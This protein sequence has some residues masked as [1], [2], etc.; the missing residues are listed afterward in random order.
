VEE[1]SD[2]GAV[3]VATARPSGLQGMV[4]SWKIGWVCTVNVPVGSMPRSGLIGSWLNVMRGCVH[5]VGHGFGKTGV[6]VRTKPEL[7][8]VRAVGP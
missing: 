2:A 4:V 6:V 1:V 5:G 8:A 3:G 7:K